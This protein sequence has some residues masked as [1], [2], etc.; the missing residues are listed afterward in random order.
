MNTLVLN[1][2]LRF[3]AQYKRREDD[4]A[5]TKA[6]NNETNISD[7]DSDQ[8]RNDASL[9]FIQD[10][11]TI[12]MSF[13]NM[14]DHFIGEID[15]NEEKFTAERKF[16]LDSLKKC[17]TQ[18]DEDDVRIQ[19]AEQNYQEE[20]AHSYKNFAQE[21][22]SLICQKAFFNYQIQQ[23]SKRAEIKNLKLIQKIEDNNVV[24]KNLNEKLDEAKIDDPARNFI[25]D[26]NESF[27]IQKDSKEDR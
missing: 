24:E 2:Q 27:D 10:Y 14:V 7:Y 20:I 8:E 4:H 12:R 25:G 16:F 3:K 17:Q 6:S 23:V 11:Q 5:Q 18:K 22:V 1:R 21:Q 15:E 26:S 19:E 9:M 13:I